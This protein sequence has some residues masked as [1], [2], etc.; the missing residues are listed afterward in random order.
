M[1]YL[2]GYH[3]SKPLEQAT[4]Q[5]GNYGVRPMQ[6]EHVAGVS[7][8]ADLC[9]EREPIGP[10]VL[11]AD[12]VAAFR[13]NPEWETLPVV[14]DGKPVGLLQRDALLLLLSKPLYPEIYN[15]KPVSR[16][17]ESGAVVID[18]RSRLSQASRLITRN[19]QSRINEEFIVARDGPVSWSGAQRGAA[20]S[21]HRGKGF[22]MH[23]SPIR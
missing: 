6:V 15:R 3:I 2:Q 19:R 1:D 9:F 12:A 13:R 23:S 16:V 10:Q 8:V 4:D 20:A 17:M 21:H 11:I 18:E 7:C 22:G 14:H 5:T